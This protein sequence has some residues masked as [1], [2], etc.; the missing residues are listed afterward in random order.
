MGTVL[1]P[2]NAAL[3]ALVE[4]VRPGLVQINNGRGERGRDHLAPRRADCHKRLCHTPGAPVANAG[5]QTSV[6]YSSP[7]ALA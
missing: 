2:V 5:S 1:Q 3:A 6:F 4:C 7:R